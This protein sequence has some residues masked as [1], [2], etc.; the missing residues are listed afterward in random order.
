MIQSLHLTNFKNFRDA[1]LSLGKLTLLVGT[2]ASGKSNLR[3]GFRFLHGIGLGYTL[4]DIIGE[5]YIGGVPVWQGIRGG[6]R[7][8]A[9]HG[10]ESFSL[11]CRLGLRSEYFIHKIDVDVAGFGL[12][13]RVRSE[14]L[15]WK[16]FSIYQSV[17]GKGV[18]KRKLGEVAVRYGSYPE[19]RQISTSQPI[20]SQFVHDPQIVKNKETS[21]NLYQPADKALADLQSMKFL[22]LSPDAMRIPSV[23]GQPLGDRGENLS[24]VLHAICAAPETKE[25]VLEWIRQLTPLDVTDLDFVADQTGKILVTLIENGGLRTSAYSASDGTLRFLALIAAMLGPDPARFYFIEELDTGIHPTRLHLLLQLIEQTVTRRHIRVVA[26]TH[27][28][29]LLGF[30]G[31]ES[32]EAATLVYRLPHHGEAHLRRIL[33]IPEARQVLATRNLSR[34]HESGWLENAVTFLEAEPDGQAVR[35]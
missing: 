32:R 24:S 9:Y 12:N 6:T 4:S 16:T 1:T 14:S 31:E 11:E 3:D 19:T 21:G 35:R 23:P 22:E 25:A 20:L 17:R 5:K 18:A 28:P 13:P 7:E 2:N 10:A 29:Q 34:L 33:D 30:L 27:S 15:Y 26:T 8:I